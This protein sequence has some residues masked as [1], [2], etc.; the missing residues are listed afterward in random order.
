MFRHLDGQRPAAALLPPEQPRRLQPGAARTPTRTRAGSST[1]SSTRSS[2]A[3]TRRS[4]APARRWCSS[5]PTQI[6]ETLARQDAWATA[7]GAR[8]RA[9]LQDGRVYV[10]NGGAAAVNVPLTGTTVGDLYGG[11][12][13][14]WVS[15][16]AGAQAD[17]RAGRPGERG[18]ARRLGQRARR[19][20]R[21]TSATGTWTGTPAIA[22]RA[23]VAALRRERRC[24]EHRRGDRA[25][26]TSSTEA[27]EG[28]HAAGRGARRQL[29]LVG[30]PGVL[31]ADRAWSRRSPRR[32][33]TPRDDGRRAAVTP[34]DR[35]LPA[36]RRRTPARRRRSPRV[37]PGAPLR[38]TQ[39]SS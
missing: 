1:R 20:R 23:A 33:P 24:A 5:R 31:G 36:R 29:D 6:A 34:K 2:G 14:G 19:A 7:R 32:T 38:L 12:R 25:R 8:S 22:L 39:G 28:Q 11:Q 35:P 9:W 16:A 26:A 4:T 18:A 27:D 30:Q 21:C 37:T 13:S 10:R 3:T 17:V 15:L